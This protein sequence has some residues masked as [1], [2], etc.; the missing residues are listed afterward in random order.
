MIEDFHATV[1]TVRDPDGN[2]LTLHRR[3]QHCAI[4]SLATVRKDTPITPPYRIDRGTAI[5]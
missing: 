4:Q 2:K 5:I 3:K 1:A